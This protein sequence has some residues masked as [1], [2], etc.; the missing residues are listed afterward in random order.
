MAIDGLVLNWPTSSPRK[1][2]R[3]HAIVHPAPP[4]ASIHCGLIAAALSP[5]DSG[6]VPL[7]AG[8]GTNVF[9]QRVVVKNY[10]CLK[11][12][13]VSLNEKLRRVVND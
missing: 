2:A 9:I 10:R 4:I 13:N 8:G 3:A 5:Q 7:L 1:I 11:A 12:A 6:I